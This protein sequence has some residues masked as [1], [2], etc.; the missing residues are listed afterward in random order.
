MSTIMLM[1]YHKDRLYQYFEVVSYN[2][3]N[4][5]AIKTKCFF[6]LG[7]AMSWNI[8]RNCVSH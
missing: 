3:I 2:V 5:R 8:V 7:L 4:L 1:Y 6:R